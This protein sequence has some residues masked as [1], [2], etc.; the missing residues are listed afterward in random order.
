M[1]CAVDPFSTE[2]MDENLRDVRI[3]RDVYP[4]CSRWASTRRTADPRCKRRPSVA[5]SVKILKND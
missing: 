5:R 4:S 1:A 2:K 3:G